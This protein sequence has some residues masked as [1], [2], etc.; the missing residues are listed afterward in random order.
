MEDELYGP[1]KKRK[2]IVQP[3]A[4]YP[5]RELK[6]PGLAS[7]NAQRNRAARA[8]QA[9]QAPAPEP[10]QRPARQR[11]RLDV[12]APAPSDNM[13]DIE[14]RRRSERIAAA[15]L[16]KAQHAETEAEKKRWDDEVKKAIAEGKKYKKAVAIKV[17]ELHANASVDELFALVDILS[18]AG[19]K[20]ASLEASVFAYEKQNEEE[21]EKANSEKE[22]AML[23]L[24]LTEFIEQGI[25]AG[26]GLRYAGD[27]KSNAVLL[28]SSILQE[29][30]APVPE[31]PHFKD[32]NYGGR[33]KTKKSKKS[34]RA[35]KRKSRT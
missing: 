7:I 34:R 29:M 24:G 3:G 30:G 27:K 20:Y 28:A 13:E 33:R 10:A 8:A 22:N 5:R 35:T 12:P 21:E 15:G 11:R 23:T 17:R 25:K 19:E 9:A 18:W 6:N 31:D 26:E 32:V 16:A 2:Y 1:I 4:P 14:S